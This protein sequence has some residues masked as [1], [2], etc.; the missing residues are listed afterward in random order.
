MSMSQLARTL[1]KYKKRHKIFIS[2]VK[3]RQLYGSEVRKWT[4]F[5]C[6]W[7]FW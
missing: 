3:H 2:L 1:W 7:Q 4:G 5:G 6:P